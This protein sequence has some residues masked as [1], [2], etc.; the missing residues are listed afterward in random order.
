M[1]IILISPYLDIWS[2]GIRTLSACLKKEKCDVQLIFLP[3]FFSNLSE[4]FTSRFE[5][6]TLDEVVEISRGADLIG[7]SLMTNYFDNVIQI[8]QRIKKDLNIPVLWGGIHPTIR[9]R[10]CLDHADMVCLGEGEES[11]LELVRKMK[12]GQ[13]YHDVQNIWFKNND[14]G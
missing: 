5:D 14:N 2:F 8:T 10:E 7:I 13:N 9:P 4:H 1:K 6:K 11:V 12:D 3:R